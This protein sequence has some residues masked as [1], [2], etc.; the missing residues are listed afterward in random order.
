[1]ST[2]QTP[3]TSTSTSGGSP[4]PSGYQGTER[5]LWGGI[6]LAV[7]TFWLFAGTMGTVAPAVM[8]DINATQP[9]VN[10]ASMNL[11]VSITALFSGLFIVLMGGLADRIGRV[12]ITLI[13]IVLGIVGSL[14]LV[15]ASG[16]AALPLLLIGRAIQASPRP[17]S[18]LPRWPW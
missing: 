12:R 6:V 13:G 17:A 8:A 7:V 9:R 3:T 16:A 11:A 15:F 14:L 4:K 2:T 10:S 5:L 1:M 18:C